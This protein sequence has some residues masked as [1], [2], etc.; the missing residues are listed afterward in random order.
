M[1]Q[2]SSLTFYTLRAKKGVER[3]SGLWPGNSPTAGAQ[4]VRFSVSIL[5]FKSWL[6]CSSQPNVTGEWQNAIQEPQEARVRLTGRANK[7]TVH[8]QLCHKRARLEQ[9]EDKFQLRQARY[10][11]VAFDWFWAQ[12]LEKKGHEIIICWWRWYW[13]IGISWLVVSLSARSE[14]LE[15][16]VLY[17]QTERRSYRK[18]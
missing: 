7:P 6:P 9:K 8:S 2:V 13:S 14:R 3:V 11:S 1:H 10:L 17:F 16:L 5:W 18:R 12:Q 4:S 15:S